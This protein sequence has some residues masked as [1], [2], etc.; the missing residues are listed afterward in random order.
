MYIYVS[1][2]MCEYC[3]NCRL[4][5]TFHI[6]KRHAT[7]MAISNVCESL[8]RAHAACRMPHAAPSAR[9]E[10]IAVGKLPLNHGLH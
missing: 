10:G 1:P 2:G 5:A 7:N 3:F 4:W 9:D 6:F 8:G